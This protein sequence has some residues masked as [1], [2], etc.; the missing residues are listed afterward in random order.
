MIRA[1]YWGD[2]RIHMMNKTVLVLVGL[3][4]FLPTLSAKQAIPLGTVL[5]VALNGS[6]SSSKVHAGQTIGSISARQNQGL[7]QG[8]GQPDHKISDSEIVSPRLQPA[9]SLLPPGGVC[10]ELDNENRANATAG[11]SDSRPH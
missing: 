6:L 5:P 3:L 8:G 11:R 1:V 4:A 10:L 9:C 7:V 2:L